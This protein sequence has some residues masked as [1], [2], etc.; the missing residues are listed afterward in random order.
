[1]SHP[2]GILIQITLQIKLRK[3]TKPSLKA[4]RKFL[5]HRTWFSWGNFTSQICWMGNIVRHKQSRKFLESI[6]ISVGK[7]IAH[8]LLVFIGKEEPIGDDII[9]GIFGCNDLKYGSQQS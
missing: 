1:M 8:F 3:C 7:V 6:G 2:T 5:N 9:S 4:L